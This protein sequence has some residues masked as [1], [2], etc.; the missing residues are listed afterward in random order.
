MQ[1]AELNRHFLAPRKTAN[2]KSTNVKNRALS[3]PDSL[4]IENI[5]MVRV[6]VRIGLDLLVRRTFRAFLQ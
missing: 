6:V 1:Q 5:A 4:C 3:G 2:V